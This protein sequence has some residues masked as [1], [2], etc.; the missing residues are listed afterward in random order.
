MLER[1][2]HK[3]LPVKIQARFFLGSRVFSG[4]IT[5]ISKRGIFLNTATLLPENFV[6]EIIVVLND[7]TLQFPIKVKRVSKHEEFCSMTGV[8]AE[9][10]YVSKRWTDY[11]ESSISDHHEEQSPAR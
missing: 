8:G 10:L 11:Y 2:A 6:L 4:I 5:S 3:R 9:I 1:R 7:Q